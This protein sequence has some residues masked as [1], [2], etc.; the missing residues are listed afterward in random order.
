M[1]NVGMMRNKTNKVSL[2]VYIKKQY[3]Y[4]TQEERLAILADQLG[5][6]EI[7]G[8]T[9]LA[10]GKRDKQ[11]YFKCERDAKTFLSY[12]TVKQIILKEYDLI[13]I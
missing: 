4:S 3:K 5:G 13:E 10:T 1:H 8:G 2:L 11:Y 7:G 9:C 12:P 6:K